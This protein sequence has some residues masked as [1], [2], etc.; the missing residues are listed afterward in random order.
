MIQNILYAFKFDPKGVRKAFFWEWLHGI[1]IASPSGILLI[2]IW[3]LF[4]ENPD[5]TK[6]WASISF[7][8]VLF[9]IQLYVANKAMRFSNESVYEMSRKMRLSLGN[10]LQRLSLGYYKKRDPG[11]LAA[12]VLQDVGNFEGIFGHSIPNI[13]NAIIATVVLSLF[14]F[15]LDFRL[16]ASLIA[17]VLLAIP[18]VRL[19]KLIVV[20]FGS[21]VIEAR[22][23]TGARFLEYVQGIQHIKS[24][25][26]TGT[27]FHSLD[28]A[29]DDLRRES[30]RTEAL[31]GPLIMLAGVIFELGFLLMICIALY[32]LSGGSL[33]AKIL[34]AF[35]IIGY[36]LYEPMKLLMVEY[37][38]LSYMNISLTRV[39]NLLEAKEQDVGE[40]KSPTTFDISFEDVHFQYVE[41]KKTLD[42]ISFKAP[43]GTMT[44]LVGPSGAGKTTI[45]S[46]IARFWD[47]NQGK[48][49]IGGVDV[50]DMAP[51]KVYSLISEVFQE[52]YLFD[53]SIYNNILIGKPE[54]SEA[55]LRAAAEKAQVLE[56]ADEFP[57]G[58]H[59]KV[60]EGGSR[61]SGGQKQRISIARALLKDAP[62]VLLDEAT[63]SLD[64]EN[65]IYIQRAI[66]EL[67]K[68]KTV[69]VIAHKLASI[70]EADQIL[71]LNDA[72]IIEFGTHEELLAKNGLYTKLWNIQQ[73]ASGW[74]IAR[75]LQSAST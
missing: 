4:S 75:N 3:E 53:D 32:F 5:E 52:V 30:I 60:G 16:A 2:V 54:A 19:S 25:G 61:L 59:T 46:L 66:Q 40:N 74:K 56:F 1:F 71:I 34:I 47:V 72:K 11:D 38:V 31:P 18:L 50:Q 58:L 43:M 63:A 24:Y 44:A 9:L 28:K 67:V 62:I 65:E 27:K 15:Y 55:E 68:G 69:V 33:E 42:G 49:L 21:K 7:M 10:K 20:K 8:A 64:P 17:A 57:E 6:I 73:K 35:L 39:I 36:R 70:Q 26:M 51:T 29:L 13:A 45:T 37:P 12:I 23:R 48:V 22:N 14:L 41:G